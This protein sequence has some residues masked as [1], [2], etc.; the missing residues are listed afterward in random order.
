MH[1]EIRE[2]S[3]LILGWYENDVRLSKDEAKIKEAREILRNALKSLDV[4]LKIDDRYTK[5]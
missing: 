3:N 4:W 2:K 1:L 5:K